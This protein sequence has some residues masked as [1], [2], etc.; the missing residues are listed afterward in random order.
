MVHKKNRPRSKGK[1]RGRPFAK[2]N[3]EGK[4]FGR[5]L[6]TPGHESGIRRDNIVPSS[7][8]SI[9]RLLQEEFKPM[10]KKQD[11]VKVEMPKKEDIKIGI[12]EKIEISPIEPITVSL[13]VKENVE[14]C[15]ILEFLE[16]KNGKNHLK[17]CLIQKPNRMFRIQTFL[18]DSTEIRPVSYTGSSTAMSFWNLLKKCLN[19]RKI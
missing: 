19:M 2:G 17:I 10:S 14:E 11:N 3:N 15:K 4:R 5:V 13:D 16:F 7:N 9:L 1:P 18:N 12:P 8:E 6:A